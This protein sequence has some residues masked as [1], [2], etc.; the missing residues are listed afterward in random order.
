[1][2][3]VRDR[4]TNQS[5]GLAY[6]QYEHPEEADAAMQQLDKSEVQGRLIHLLPAQRAPKREGPPPA[7]QPGLSKFKAE[8]EAALKATAGNKTAWNALFMR[9]VRPARTIHNTPHPSL[10]KTTVDVHFFYGVSLPLRSL[11]LAAGQSTINQRLFRSGVRWARGGV[12]LPFGSPCSAGRWPAG[13]GFTGGVA[14]LVATSGLW[15]EL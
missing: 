2:H 3:L 10:F 6:V 15:R 5:K 1:V 7:T 14:E 9:C 11:C 8:R 13:A 4:H 12:G